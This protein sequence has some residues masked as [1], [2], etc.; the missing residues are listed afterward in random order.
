M[1]EDTNNHHCITSYAVNNT[2]LPMRQATKPYPEFRL[3]WS[4]VRVVAQQLKHVGEPA[5]IGF[6]DV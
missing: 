1:V 5:R 2:M 6:T 3:R 4:G